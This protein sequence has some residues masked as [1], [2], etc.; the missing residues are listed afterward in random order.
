VK[1]ALLQLVVWVEKAL[2]Q[3]ETALD[4]FLDI[5][6]V[7]N[8]TFYDSVCAALFKHGV[9]YTIVWW[10]RATLEGCM[11]AATLGEFSKRV[12]V[13][14]GCSQGGVLLSLPWCLVV[15]GLI[16][17]LT[18]G[19]IYIQDYADDICL[20]AVGKFPNT[21]SGL[22]QWALHTAETWCG[23]VR[24]LVNPDNTGSFPFT[25]KRK[26]PGFLHDTLLGL[27]YVAVCWSSISG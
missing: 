13:F 17:R 1:T 27:L 5:E 3:Q 2:D 15:D 20:L 7:C 24:L 9:A 6:G 21:I 4:V 14:R 18:G 25:R 10:I 8:N 22:I 23:K 16:A 26:L 12:V 19:V 11:A